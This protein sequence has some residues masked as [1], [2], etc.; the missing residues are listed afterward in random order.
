MRRA[1]SQ[2]LADWPQAYQE[3]RELWEAH[4]KGFIEHEPSSYDRTYTK[5]LASTYLLAELR[6]YDSLPLLVDSHKVEA[7][8]IAELKHYPAWQVPVPAPI[9]LYAMHRLVSSFPSGRM[10][11]EARALHAAYMKFADEHIPPVNTRTGT[12]WNADYDESD[13][14]RRA[15][16]PK[17]IVLHDQPKIELV[18]YPYKFTDG[19]RMQD[20]ISP[21]PH[22]RCNVWFDHIERFVAAAFPDETSSTAPARD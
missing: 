2:A 7:G 14:L 6:D 4:P 13:P 15:V 3:E 12:S 9:S 17:G 5:A 21:T 8:W 18:S 1:L 11:P 22:E 16:D 10:T 19:E 20:I